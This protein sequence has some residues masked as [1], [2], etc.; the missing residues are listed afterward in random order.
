M[1]H[2]LVKV[3][4]LLPVIFLSTVA[5]ANVSSEFEEAV[6]LNE[7]GMYIVYAEKCADNYW[8]EKA[9]SEAFVKVV[10]GMIKRGISQGRVSR[11]VVNQAVSG[12]ETIIAMGGFGYEQQELCQGFTMLNSQF[13]QP[14]DRY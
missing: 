4:F 7:A 6:S 12:A 10:E 5:S 8:M 14:K 9:D 2:K 13:A 11:Q 3:L 1:K